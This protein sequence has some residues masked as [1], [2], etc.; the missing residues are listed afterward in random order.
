MISDATQYYEFWWL[1]V[2]PGIA[3]ASTVLAVNIL[4]EYLRNF[5]DP[6]Q[7]VR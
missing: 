4:G 6:R 1:P 3:I 7:V 2:F 5:W